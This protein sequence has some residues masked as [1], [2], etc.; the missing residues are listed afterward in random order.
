MIEMRTAMRI[1][2]CNQVGEKTGGS[3]KGNDGRDFFFDKHAG[4]IHQIIEEAVPEQF[5]QGLLELHRDIG[6]ILRY[7][8]IIIYSA[9]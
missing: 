3:T 7:I 1:N 6:V 5:Q 2:M 8:H 9:K 4:N